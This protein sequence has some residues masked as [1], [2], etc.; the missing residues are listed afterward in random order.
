MLLGDLLTAVQEKIPLKVVVFNNGSLGFVE[1]EMKV[2]GL[3]DAYPTLRNPDFARLSEVMGFRGWRVDRNEAL[4][5]AMAD[6][7]GH[8]GPALLDVIVNRQELVMPPQVEATQVLGTM[9][10]GAI[11]HDGLRS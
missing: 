1:L 10:Y 5:A 11:E 6:F 4:E 3:L 7:L 8:P 2:E 9:L